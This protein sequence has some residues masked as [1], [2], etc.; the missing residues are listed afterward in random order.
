MTK[1]SDFSIAGVAVKHGE[2]RDVRLKISETYTGDEIAIPIRV[3]RAR[4]PGPTVFI[5]AAVHGDELNGTG[6]IHELVYGSPVSLKCGTLLLMPV[7]NV[8]GFE[9]Q[10]RYLPDRRDLNRFFPGVESGSL[11]S[12]IAFTIMRE[13]IQKCDYGID[14]HTAATYR[15]NFPNVRGDLA[16][17]E[18]KQL[19]DA[20]GCELI[21]D[22]KG[23]VGSLRREACRAGCPTIVL[24]AGE[25]YKLEPSMLETGVRGIHNVLISLGMASGTLS[26]PPYQAHIRNTTWVRAEVGG[27]IRFHVRLGDLI[28]AGQPIAS[29]FSILG[30]QQNSLI[31]PTDG[32]VLGL[33]TMPAIKPGE[34]VCHIAIVSK[35]MKSIRRAIEQMSSKHLHQRVR[36]DLATNISGVDSADNG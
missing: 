27:I 2:S 19:A 8:L 28:E 36:D 24:E 3:K 21:V 17:P 5:S 7:V 15:T 29:N 10:E 32:I 4:K 23:P 6:I 16:I 13:V 26:K 35:R 11:T 20:F 25:P 33:T 1:P 18:V 12:R 34:P 31:S 14:L 30:Q 22:S 9:N